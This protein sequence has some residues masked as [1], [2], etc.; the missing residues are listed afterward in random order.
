MQPYEAGTTAAGR[1]AGHHSII[2]ASV[3]EGEG[4][5]QLGFGTSHIEDGEGRPTAQ[6]RRHPDRAS[7]ILLQ[8]V[9][10]PRPAG[11]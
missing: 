11:L 2:P 10:E 5:S 6:A 4:A 8:L 7:Q 9:E 3:E 1:D